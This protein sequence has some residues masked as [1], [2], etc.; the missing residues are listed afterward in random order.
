MCVQVCFCGGGLCVAG[1]V[2]LSLI[3]PSKYQCRQ[4][5]KF[6]VADRNITPS[7]IGNIVVVKG[8]ATEDLPLFLSTLVL[9]LHRFTH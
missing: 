2:C 6:L 8:K 7:D 1:C 9:L 4:D 5:K 3:G